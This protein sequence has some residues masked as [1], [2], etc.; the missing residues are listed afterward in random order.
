MAFENPRRIFPIRTQHVQATLALV[1]QLDL[2][3]SYQQVYCGRQH[4]SFY[5]IPPYGFDGE[6]IRN[7]CSYHATLHFIE[8]NW[9]ITVKANTRVVIQ[10]NQTRP[11]VFDRC[12]LANLDPEDSEDPTTVEGPAIFY[13]REVNIHN[14]TQLE[15]NNNSERD[16][17]VL[18]CKLTDTL[19]RPPRFRGPLSRQNAQETEF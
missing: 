10:A 17:L 12:L 3:R 14:N 11:N 9:V 16:A 1:S 8:V 4:N 6:P 2:E 18:L 19:S 15:L 7:D 5:L 13:F